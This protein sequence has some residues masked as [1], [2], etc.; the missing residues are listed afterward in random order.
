MS[1]AG[2]SEDCPYCGGRL[3]RREDDDPDTV[4]KRLTTYAALAGP[5]I[6]LYSARPGYIEVDGLQLPDK[7]TADLNA[8]LDARR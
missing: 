1:G 6:D 3:V 7:V 8:A 4:R 2:N 5:L